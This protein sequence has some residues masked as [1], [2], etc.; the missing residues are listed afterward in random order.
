MASRS[1][2]RS[3]L[4][5]VSANIASQMRSPSKMLMPRTSG[6]S[7]SRI[8]R[9]ISRPLRPVVAVVDLA[10]EAGVGAH[11]GDHGAAREDG[12]GAAAEVLLQRDL[13]RDGFDAVD[14]HGGLLLAPYCPTRAPGK[15]ISGGPPAVLGSRVMN[16]T[17]LDDYQDTIRTLACFSKVA[18]HK[19]TIW[20]DHTKDVDTLAGRLKDTEA[21]ALIRE[22]TPIRAPLIERLDKLRLI[23]QG[24]VFPHIDVEAC[25]RRGILVCSRT[26][27]GPAVVRDRRAH[28]GARDRRV[29]SHSPGDGGA[30]GRQVAGLSDRDRPA[31]QDARHLRLRQDRRGRGRLRQG[32]RH[33]R[34]GV[35]A[36]ELDRPGAD[37]R[38]RRRGEQGRAVRGVGRGVAAPATDRRD[39]RHRHR[40]RP[41]A[42]EADGA[43]RQHEP[44]R[45]D[46][47]GRARG[48]AARR[49]AGHGGGRR[50][51]GGAA[52]GRRAIRCWR[53]TT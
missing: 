44:G 11:A 51:R 23:S 20:N 53:W 47:A 43:A 39:P 37:G 41:G 15:A 34:A 9:T 26:R 28:V 29:P 27:P 46:R 32:V 52:A 13:D 31:R 50:L 42:H 5:W 38:R 19:V 12:V 8:S 22:R 25:T 40:R 24:G 45:A 18:G 21:L 2:L 14:A 4:M 30:Q 33:E 17:I 48:R 6:V 49:A 7:V 35:G 36:R 3:R 10:D 16:I 1:T